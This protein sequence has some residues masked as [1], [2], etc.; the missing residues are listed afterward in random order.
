MGGES[1]QSSIPAILTTNNSCA[2]LLGTTQTNVDRQVVLFYLFPDRL[3]TGTVG[4]AETTFSSEFDRRGR[5]ALAGGLSNVL[6]V[7]RPGISS[8]ML[9]AFHL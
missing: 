8:C 5:R 9:D 2:R 4:N 1:G 3:A 7:V 6:T